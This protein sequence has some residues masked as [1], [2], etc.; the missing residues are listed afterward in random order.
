MIIQ[1]SVAD[2]LLMKAEALWRK[3]GSATD[4]AALALVNQIRPRAGLTGLTSLD[5][6]L[7]FDLAGGRVPGGELFN[8]R[9]REMF[10]EH[11]RGQ[12]LIRFGLWAQLNKWVL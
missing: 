10:A 9:G 2:V 4:A 11:S 6:A 8:E 12:D 5:G 7:S 1:Y 3:S